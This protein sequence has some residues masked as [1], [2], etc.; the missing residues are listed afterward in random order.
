VT[1]KRQLRAVLD[2]IGAQAVARLPLP[3]EGSPCHSPQVAKI[4]LGE[5][6]AVAGIAADLA[7]AEVDYASLPDEESAG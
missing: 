4:D 7:R 3:E 2:R 6:A 5:L 1:P